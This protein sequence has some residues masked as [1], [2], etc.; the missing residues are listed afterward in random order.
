[1]KNSKNKKFI[2]YKKLDLPKINQEIL[3]YWEIHNVFHQSI[4][5]REGKFPYIFYEG[6]P[7][8][9]G[10]PG[11]H[12]VIAR[13][14][15]DIFC[16]YKTMKG[17]QVKRKAGW[18]THGLP[19]ELEVEKS[20]NIVK[21]DIGKKISI[22][23]YNTACRQAV[24]KYTKEWENLTRKI[25]YWVDM[26]SPYLT[27]DNQYI[28]TLWWLLKKLYK[29]G[30]LYKDY[31]IQPYSPAAGTGLST[32]ELNQPGCYQNVKD[33]SCT[34]LFKI[35]KPLSEMKGFG[36]VFFLVW[37][38]TPW[39]LPSNTALCININIEYIAVQS[40]NPYTGKPLTVIIAKDLLFSYFNK[41]ALGIPL[42]LYSL[43][44]K[45][46]PFR[47]S[48]TWKG[49]MLI[50][51]KYEQLI[52]WV[53][54]KDEKAFRVIKGDFVTIDSGTGIV[55]IAPTFGIDDYKVAKAEGIPFLLMLNKNKIYS[56]MVDTKGKFFLLEDL[57]KNFV[58]KN[59]NSSLYSKFAGRFVKNTYDDNLLNSYLTLDMDICTMLKQQNRVFKIKKYMHNYPHCWRTNKPILYYLLDSWFIRTTAVKDRMV[60]LNNTI[61]WKPKSIGDSKFNKWLENIQD[62]NLSR[63]RYWGTPLP[64]WRTED[65]IEE[66]CIGSIKELMAEIQK[67]IDSG[68]MIENPYK[69]VKCI[70]LHRPY[71]DKIILI[72]ESGKAMKRELD[73]IDVWFDSGAMPYAQ[74]HYPFKNA[75]LIDNNC[76]FPADFISEGVDQTRGWFFALH[77]ISVIIKDSIAFRNVIST[78]LIL[79]HKGNK[80]S[81]HLGNVIDP[82]EIIETYGS[83]S[84]RWYLIANSL[85]W[86]NLKFN[87]GGIEE[88]H[89]KFFGTLHNIYSFFAI[90]ANIDN[91]NYDNYKK[92]EVPLEKRPEIDCWI[93]SL[94]NSLIKEVDEQFSIYEPTRAVRAISHFVND[95]LSNWYVRLNRKRFWK[96]S[97]DFN[98]LSAYQT[99]YTCL[100]TVSQ[101]M[102][103][104][105]PF[106]AD[107]L[108]IDLVQGT[109]ISVHLSNFPLV[110]ASL[111]DKFLEE[112]MQIAQDISSMGLAL[113]KRVNIK[114]R[115]PLSS[116]MV[117]VLNKKQKEIIKS[118]ENFILYEVNVKKIKY[119]DNTN[120][121]LI[122]KIKLNFKKLGPRYGK[123]MKDLAKS[124]ENIS[125]ESIFQ[126][127]KNGE[128]YIKISEQSVK[129]TIDD[130]EI[131]SEDIPG[132]LVANRGK[133]TVALDITIT[134][135]LKKEGIARDLVNYIQNMRKVN[136]FKITDRINLIIQSN[137][138]INDAIKKNRQY[139]IDQTLANRIDISNNLMKGMK[140][141]LD[142][143][144]LL[145]DIIKAL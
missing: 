87:K 120:K 91:Y 25:G 144:S 44:D 104:I 33:T 45:L 37:T 4:K 80:M 77:V 35:T 115:Q 34:V 74:F 29:K 95:N 67:A 72:S 138:Y 38:T 23:E 83:D 113:R 64:I 100:K 136:G 76:F 107:K 50:D 90:Y 118:I 40:Y 59:I 52:P 139:I 145:V 126:L 109:Q 21:E 11:I 75:K 105:A 94:L 17:Y 125:Q 89:R 47:I 43:G 92:L 27:C 36:D 132:W 141:K 110:N 112:K 20:L 73:L 46:I 12:H 14:I 32:H 31:A 28:E 102:S 85:P 82:I 142:D 39:T 133:W 1:M 122:K 22:E 16:R 18:D 5:I 129:I 123:I 69:N 49:S 68:I 127:E 121:I 99:L 53:N 116:L 19:V 61:N 63:S 58:K 111:I 135:K 78:G 41:K 117:A 101:L 108:Y 114:V 71:I 57:D 106:Y 66:K 88:V 9:N 6:P 86:D 140:I 84:L 7:S 93:L 55:H 30:L 13:S 62:W 103:P 3:Q 131:L 10:K 2:E 124:I 26:D 134:D 81:K 137:N 70:D 24:T 143:F 119:V 130:V 60:E 97:M 98:K 56:P 65:G 79:D 51:M 8:A 42:E 128:V 96:N 15:K 48:G 54:L